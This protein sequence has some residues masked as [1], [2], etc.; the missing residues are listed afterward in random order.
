M[1]G[2]QNLIHNAGIGFSLRCSPVTETFSM[3]ES[4]LNLEGPKTHAS[5]LVIGVHSAIGS[6]R[7][8]ELH[9]KM[10][11]LRG[12]ADRTNVPVKCLPVTAMQ[13]QSLGSGRVHTPARRL[14]P[15]ACRIKETS[16]C[17]TSLVLRSNFP[18]LE[19]NQTRA[20]IQVCRVL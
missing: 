17:P 6:T 7:R 1:K 18:N 9:D 13:V 5:Y 15:A 16:P 11:I 10:K 12:Q 20:T 4:A 2:N 8:H 19:Q 3:R 14:Q